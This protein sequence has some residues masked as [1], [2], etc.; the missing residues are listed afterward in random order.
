MNTN[1]SSLSL[2]R[3]IDAIKK[4]LAAWGRMHPGS[5]SAQYQVC[6]NPNCR[7]MHPKHPQR[8]GPFPKL[9]YVYKGKPTCR[10]VRAG[11]VGEVL[12]RVAVYKDFRALIDKWIML[13]IQSGMIEFFATAHKGK[14]S[15][16]KSSRKIA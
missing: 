15:K 8:H 11:C 1:Q 4:K 3:E 7:C 5:V 14:L 2:E 12:R 6:G 9:S 13:S 10:F 16:G